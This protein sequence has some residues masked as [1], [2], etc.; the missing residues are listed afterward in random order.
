[1]N[2]AM[3]T[4]GITENPVANRPVFFCKWSRLD[5]EENQCEVSSDDLE[6][7]F[8]QLKEQLCWQPLTSHKSTAAE[9]FAL[10]KTQTRVKRK[11]TADSSASKRPTQFCKSGRVAEI[12][13]KMSRVKK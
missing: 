2:E 12:T 13:D 5:E 3:V 11:H 4:C 7:V 6:K 1:M 9:F 8:C 10:D